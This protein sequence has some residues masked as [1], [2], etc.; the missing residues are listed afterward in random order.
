VVL[1]VNISRKAVIYYNGRGYKTLMRHFGCLLVA[2][3]PEEMSTVVE[4]QNISN[5][6]LPGKQDSTLYFLNTTMH[7]QK[8]HH[9]PNPPNASR[10]PGFHNLAVLVVHRMFLNH[11]NCK[12]LSGVDNSQKALFLHHRYKAFSESDLV[13]EKQLGFDYALRNWVKLCRGEVRTE[14]GQRGKPSH[15]NL[16]KGL[17]ERVTTLQENFL[18][19]E[20]SFWRRTAMMKLIMPTKFVSSQ[21]RQG[22]G[23]YLVMVE[24]FYD[25]RKY[26]LNLT[27]AQAFIVLCR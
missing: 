16:I 4:L 13:V 21:N 1:T 24:K 18:E 15:A 7:F 2:W 19:L 14:R 27:T 26:G 8:N 5:V 11:M 20:E 25:H 6:Q 10:L 3:A 12:S 9:H 23:M 17:E 22:E